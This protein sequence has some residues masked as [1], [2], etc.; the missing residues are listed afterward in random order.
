MKILF[1][2]DEPDLLDQ[3]KIF[4]KRELEDLDIDT[5]PSPPPEALELL[6]NNEYDGVV[7][8]YKMPEMSGLEFLR[9]V[10]E[11]KNIDLPFI[12][13]TGKGREEVAM[14]ALNL[15][16]D[17]YLQK[18]GDPRSQYGVLSR[19][20]VQEVR[21]WERER[22]LRNI[23]WLFTREVED[24]TYEPPYGDLTELNTER[25][26]LDSVGEDM[27]RDIVDHF[28]SLLDTSCA[29]YEKNGD[30][31]LG[32][33]ASGWCR[34]LDRE[35]RDLCNTKENQEALESGDWLCHE[36]CWGASKASMERGGLLTL[37]VT[38]DSTYTQFRLEREKKLLDL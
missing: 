21:N 24:R 38:E 20:I 5:V 34:F 22:E 36:S 3:A 8:D 9:T 7:S 13:F 26:I 2:D 12:I 19:A 10:R 1:V 4:L 35:S 18:G 33:F 28:M 15:G 27:L 16:A 31:A 17:R 14:E 11:E 37:N 30:Y 23:D 6:E 25:T 29:V 32:I